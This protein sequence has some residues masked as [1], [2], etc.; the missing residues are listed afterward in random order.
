MHTVIEFH[1]D[2]GP[3]ITVELYKVSSKKPYRKVSE[4]PMIGETSFVFLFEVMI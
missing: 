3:K 4:Q 2:L 1:G